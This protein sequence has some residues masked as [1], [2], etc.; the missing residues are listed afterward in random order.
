VLPAIDYTEDEW[1]WV[2][3]YDHARVGQVKPARIRRMRRDDLE[4]LAGMTQPHPEMPEDEAAKL[5]G[6]VSRARS[7]L[8]RRRTVRTAILAAAIGALASLVGVAVTLI[9][10]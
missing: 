2:L 3:L 6:N 9:W 4:F 10:K 1:R 7:E 8:E 5:L